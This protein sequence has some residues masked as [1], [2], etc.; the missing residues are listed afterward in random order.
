[1][2]KYQEV[3]DETLIQLEFD[4][5]GDTGAYMACCDCGLVHLY[6]YSLCVDEEGSISLQ[7]QV[8][9]R[10]RSTS[11]LRRHNSGSLQRG[12]CSKWEMVRKGV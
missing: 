10:Q 1:M 6:V 5:E 3:D 8:V 7:V 4:E 9:R 11:Q 2:S 12:E